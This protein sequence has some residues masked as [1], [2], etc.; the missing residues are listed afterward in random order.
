MASRQKFKSKRFREEH[1]MTTAKEMA[2]AVGV[3]LRTVQSWDAGHKQPSP[4]A[5]RRLDEIHKEHT[6]K[7]GSAIEPTEREG[8]AP[9]RQGF[10]PS[11]R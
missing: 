4:L 6:S 8:N 3:D 5:M 7:N 1:G 10:L 2:E 11:T 9:V